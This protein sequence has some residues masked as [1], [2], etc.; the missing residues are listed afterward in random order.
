MA[1]GH[2]ATGKNF[3]L[4][5]LVGEN[6]ERLISGLELVTLGIKHLLY[7]PDVPISHVY[8]PVDGVMSMLA[9]LD[10][11][12]LVE[13]ATVGNEGMVGLPLFLGTDVTPG[14]AY[15][16]VPGK[17][18]QL[19]ADEFMR[20]LDEEPS[21]TTVLHRYTQALMVQIS[22]GTACN[23]VHPNQ[24]RC[25]RWL[26]LS[27]DRVGRDEFKLTQEFLAQMLGVRRATVNEVAGRL[28]EQG[29]IE[30]SRGVIRVLDRPR[31]EAASCRCYR[32]V[33]EE[34]DRMYADLTEGEP[35]AIAP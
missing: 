6:P 34:Y 11:G 32:I 16:Q 21:L 26:L 12:L 29:I 13:V 31:L 10:E 5:K 17:A 4:G 18:Y 3:L 2:V 14:T 8:F 15:S 24:Q 33:R 1:E 9:Q 28:Q 7:E 19:P 23:R 35:E 22:Q 27:H 30:Y 20:L 25:A